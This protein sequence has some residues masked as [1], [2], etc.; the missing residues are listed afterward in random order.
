M[1]FVLISCKLYVTFRLIALKM[2]V[3]GG[4]IFDSFRVSRFCHC[5]LMFAFSIK[6]YLLESKAAMLK[7]ILTLVSILITNRSTRL[8]LILTLNTNTNTNTNT[9]IKY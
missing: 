9:N 8:L 2:G 7:L 6:A 4:L 3:L 1:T 5:L